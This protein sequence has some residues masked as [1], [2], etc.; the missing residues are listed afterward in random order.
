MI[1]FI[2]PPLLLALLAGC[3]DFPQL[4]IDMP[5]DEARQGYGRLLP[6][7]PVLAQADDTRITADTGPDLQTRAAA[8]RARASAL[9]RQT[10]IEDAVRDRMKQGVTDR[11]AQP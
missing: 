4:D 8:L 3:G 1:R 2:A 7:E 10:V 6:L 5:E 11:A 9:S